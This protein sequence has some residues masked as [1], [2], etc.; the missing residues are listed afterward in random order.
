[1]STYTQY[2]STS[3][4]QFNF[5]RIICHTQMRSW[6]PPRRF[7]AAV[8]EG[9]LRPL[10]LTNNQSR[11]Q[12][13]KMPQAC[14]CAAD[15]LR[16]LA[17]K[18][19]KP[20]LQRA[21]LFNL[22]SLGSQSNSGMPVAKTSRTHILGHSDSSPRNVKHS[23]RCPPAAHTTFHKSYTSH[24]IYATPATSKL[25]RRILPDFENIKTRSPHCD[26]L[27]NI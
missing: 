19:D 27:A 23:C 21:A 11:I 3:T 12:Q 9:A 16:R 17:P 2:A 14:S 25:L 10:D 1:M 22:S 20:R 8:A 26:A 6:H 15:L 4:L 18:I 5:H 24:K 7:P 13:R